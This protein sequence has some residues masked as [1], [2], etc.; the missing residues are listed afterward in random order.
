[1]ECSF[2]HYFLTWKNMKWATQY[3]SSFFFFFLLLLFLPP[4]PSWSSSLENQKLLISKHWCALIK[5]NNTFFF[6]KNTSGPS[7][8]QICQVPKIRIKF[9]AIVCMPTICET[10][11]QVPLIHCSFMLYNICIRQLPFYP[12]HLRKLKLEKFKQQKNID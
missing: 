3:C 10:W 4:S 5:V 11:G 12:L 9:I 6:Q 8:Y 7:R 1:M 2:N